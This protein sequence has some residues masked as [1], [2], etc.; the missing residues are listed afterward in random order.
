M[1]RLENQ[2]LYVPFVMRPDNNYT[3]PSEIAGEKNL[4]NIKSLVNN[5]LTKIILKKVSD[6]M[7]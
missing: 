2:D 6:S 3:L 4:S 7:K 5:L 1:K